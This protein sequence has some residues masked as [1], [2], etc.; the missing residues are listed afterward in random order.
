ME[1][2]KL[3]TDLIQDLIV[4]PIPTLEI[5]GKHDLSLTN[6][7]AL[8]E[9]DE[10]TDMLAQLEAVDR[11]R[12]PVFRRRA[13]NAL[14]SIML[15][16]PT[17]SSHA[18]TVRKAA[19]LYLR[20]TTAPPDSPATEPTAHDGP[21]SKPQPAPEQHAPVIPQPLAPAQPPSPIPDCSTAPAALINAAG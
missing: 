16:Q 7:L 5:C 2:T 21:A 1:H 15:Q 14:E 18:E 19:A 8:L 13:I 20:C 6:L 9:S 11:L 10:F 17:G 3:T 12:T 4:E